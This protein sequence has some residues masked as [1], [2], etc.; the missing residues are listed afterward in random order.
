MRIQLI[1]QSRIHTNSHTQTHLLRK[2]VCKKR[3]QLGAVS[4]HIFCLLLR[5]Y[6]DASKPTEHPRCYYW[7]ETSGFL[8]F[9]LFPFIL[10]LFFLFY[11]L[12]F[13]SFSC[14]L[15]FY[16][17]LGA[18]EMSNDILLSSRPRSTGL[19]TTYSTGHGC[20]C[21]KK[22]LNASKPFEQPPSGEKLSKRLGGNIGC[23]D[24]SWYKKGF[25]M[26]VTYGQQYNIVRK[27]TVILYAYYIDR[28]WQGHRNKSKV[29]HEPTY[30]VTQL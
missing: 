23:R 27:P 30:R 29:L 20:S 8:C 26:L 4:L 14:R 7:V 12:F 3:K 19:A 11:F 6:L 2:A 28:P 16:A 22:N 9:L 13:S 15:C 10:S 18:L 1:N 17:L 24:K 25:L 5:K 21:L